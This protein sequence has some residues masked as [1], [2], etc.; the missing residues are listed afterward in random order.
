MRRE[1]GGTPEAP[2]SKAAEQSPATT[3][4]RELAAFPSTMEGK[5][6]EPRTLFLDPRE[7]ART[8]VFL[9]WRQSA[10]PVGVGGFGSFFGPFRTGAFAFVAVIA[11]FAPSVK[12]RSTAA[13][14]RA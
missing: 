9:D 4:S 13:S 8:N 12:R 5:C 1:R 3:E 7:R 11:A 14:M 10:Q 2:D 6:I